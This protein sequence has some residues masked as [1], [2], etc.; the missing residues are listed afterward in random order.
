MNPFTEAFVLIERSTRPIRESADDL[1][2]QLADAISDETI[3]IL[4]TKDHLN[5]KGD[6]I[7]FTGQTEV[8]RRDTSNYYIRGNSTNPKVGNDI[9]SIEWVAN[10]LENKS[11]TT[12][13]RRR[14]LELVE[15]YQEY[16]EAYTD[17]EGY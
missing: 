2:D 5:Q 16:E 13:S 3:M 7:E 14:D 8:H 10:G 11:L 9:W 6:S 17:E 4:K 15:M 12:G 1:L